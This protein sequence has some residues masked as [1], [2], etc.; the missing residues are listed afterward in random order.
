M[1]SKKNGIIRLVVFVVILAAIVYTAIAGVDSTGAGSIYNINRGL[2]LAGGVSITYHIVEEN[3]SAEDL[4]D[5]VYRLQKRVENYST[6]AKVYTSGEDR[7]TID[8]PG[9]TDANAILAELGE[10]GT[11]YFVVDSEYADQ[12][13]GEEFSWESYSGIAIMDGNSIKDAQGVSTQNQN[14]GAIS[15]EVSLTLNDQGAEIFSKATELLVEDKAPIYI[16]YNGETVSAP[17]VQSHITGGMCSITGMSSLEDA[18][19]LAATIRIG[20]LRLELEEDYSSVVGAELGANAVSS[21][22]MAGVIGFILLIIF[23]IAIYR[24]PGIAADLALTLYVA[25]M[26][27][28]LSAF[29]VTLTLSGIAGIILGIGMAVDA[30]IIIFSRIREELEADMS[31]KT[32]IKNGFDKATSAVVDGNITTLVAAAVLYFLASGTVKGF[33]QTLAI[34]IVVSMFTALIVTRFILNAFFDLGIA[35]NAKQFGKNIRLKT[36]NFVGKKAV[37]FGLS[38]VL[39]AAALLGMVYSKATTGDA[40]NYSL[41]FKGGTSTNVTFNEEMDINNLENDV[42]PVIEDAIGSV[43]AIFT[44]IVGTNEVVIKTNT[45]TVEQRTALY[46]ALAENFG[47]DESLITN[48]N[49][50]ASVSKE[51]S[52]DAIISIIV[53]TILML[54]YILFRFK[55]IKFASSAILALIHDILVTVL[56]Y[57]MFRWSVGNTFVA[58]MLTIVGYSINATIVIFDRIR[59]NLGVM[60]K[61]D[62]TEVVNTSITQTL[63]RTVYSSLTT[64][65][66][67][68]VLYIVGVTS[69]RDF[70]LPLIIGIICGT[71]SSVCVTGNMW[72]VMKKKFPRKTA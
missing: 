25:L 52:Q 16:V 33:A 36:I 60:A 6:E 65:V 48:E 34:S 3:P 53:A 2:D 26:I 44:P 21:S 59:E 27:V 38:G 8:I 41:E 63:T 30:N 12:L 13:D 31:V 9:A 7:I 64:V 18:Q 22:L 5:T 56:F 67:V 43:G 32:A 45:L 54:I 15:Y 51:M 10:P 40:F 69:I 47:V 42:R 29:E 14:T 58:C 37:F 70:A 61:A 19:N 24:V 57:V 46:E 1:K 28:L 35:N 20:A 11:L 72:Y 23:M 39:V 17:T 68:I 62:L 49:I 55:D 4:S 50:S 66:M 71:Y